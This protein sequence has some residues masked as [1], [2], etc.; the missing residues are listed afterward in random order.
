M[1]RT[2]LRA[3][4][5]ASALTAF[6]HGVVACDD[7]TLVTSPPSTDAGTPDVTTT[8]SDAGSGDVTTP[9][10]AGMVP[11]TLS[12]KAKVGTADFKCGATYPNQG[13]SNDT[14]EP[15]DLRLF[16]QDVKL[17]DATG[18]ETPVVLDARSPWQ[19]TEV[20]LL[21]FEDGTGK[22][23]NG[24]PELNDKITGMVPAGTYTGVVF[25]NGV[26]AGIN[27]K[28]PATEPPPLSAGGMT[29]GW[30]FGHIFIKAEMSS[31]SAD[32]GLGLL[33]LGSVGCSNDPDGGDDFSK[34]PTIP[35]SQPNRNLV[36]LTGFDPATKKIV[37]DVG[38]LFQSTDL[39][40][41][42][43][44]H[45]AGAAC[46]PLFTKVGLDFDGGARL[47]TAPAFRVE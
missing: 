42:N 19:T 28:D 29:W 36:K 24:N 13:S 3:A 43:M 8:P 33:H 38:A 17:V 16:V 2:M 14:V 23:S 9:T 39:S 20:A 4:I 27:H 34:S 7:D 37:I 45:S 21:D 35:C 1:K 32:G 6:V 47:S 46:P 18:K 11:V 30:L 22:C 15:R 25:T 44:C 26:P 41:M 12:F 5:A 40:T 31:T 10:D